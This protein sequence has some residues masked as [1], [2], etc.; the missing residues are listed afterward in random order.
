MFGSLLGIVPVSVALSLV[1]ARGDGPGADGEPQYFSV[2]SGRRLVDRVDGRRDGGRMAC[3]S[4][5]RL[6][7]VDALRTTG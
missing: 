2:G 1:S 3:V 4:G 6:R 7:T 5:P